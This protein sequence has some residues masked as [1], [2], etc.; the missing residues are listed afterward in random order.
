MTMIYKEIIIKVDNQNIQFNP[1]F[2]IPIR[3][4]N[5]PV[6]HLRF[7]DHEDIYWKIEL[8][9]YNED[10]KYWK[11]KVIDYFVND[12]QVY[13]RQTST[14][15]IEKVDFEKFDWRKF[16]PLLSSYHKIKLQSILDNYNADIIYPK[17]ELFSKTVPSF[18][19]TIIGQI[20]DLPVLQ[21][22][23]PD[24]NQ[25]VRTPIIETIRVQL[26]INVSDAKF[27]LGFV[28][29]NKYI[30]EVGML[31]D[32]KIKND[33][34]LAEFDNIK[35]WF[36]KKLKTKKFKISAIITTTDGQ[37]IEASAS[38]SQ[39]DMITPDLI[40]SVKYERT[41]ALTKP[42][43]S[44]NPDK[45]LYTADDIFD[46]FETENKEGNV[47]NQSEPDIIKSLVE[48][49]HVRNRKQLEYLSGTKQSDK[50][51]IHYTLNPHF[52]FLFL[53]EGKEKYHFAWELLHSHATYIWS[54]NKLYL[55][56]D[57]LYKKIEETINV[58]REIGRE[59]YKRTL[60]NNSQNSDFTFKII[61]HDDI[62]SNL[63]NGF[64]KWRSKL[65]EQLI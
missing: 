28:T 12:I 63:D 62:T 49:E 22:I 14:R 54:I 7:R 57:D 48:A 51:K 26:S 19:R 35:F 41:I 42:P 39:I 53:I 8:I 33:H 36:A 58:V 20:G 16:E 9:E 11:V 52:G 46:L 56:I 32:F 4:T 45:S 37:F 59:N 55:G 25:Y 15:V 65:E 29:F 18:K 64:L 30:K 50:S 5:I 3:Q 61:E 23:L 17:K 6:D 47:F 1:N 10:T 13:N 27:E 60:R 38:S 21:E 43:K 31:V 40:D 44:K 2:S 24:K 34:I